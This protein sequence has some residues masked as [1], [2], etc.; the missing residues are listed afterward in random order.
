MTNIEKVHAHL[1]T[2]GVIVV[3]SYEKP[4]I[5][6][7]AK[8]VDYIRADGNGFR[9]GWPGK[10]SVYVFSYQIKMAHRASP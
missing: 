2:G 7:G 8:M 5:I 1:K 9:L 6:E 3:P 10:K 4:L